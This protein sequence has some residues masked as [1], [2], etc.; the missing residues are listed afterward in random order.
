M[1]GVAPAFFVSVRLRRCAYPSQGSFA[2]PRES[3]SFVRGIS[4]G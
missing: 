2:R 4:L 3:F 1:H